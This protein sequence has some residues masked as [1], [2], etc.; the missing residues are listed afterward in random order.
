MKDIFISHAW[1]KDELNRDNH[2]RCKLLSEQLIDNGYSVWFDSNDLYGNIDSSIMKGINN[3][4]VVLV[5]LTNKYCDKINKCAVN[6]LTNDNCYKEWN[7]SLFKQKIIIPVLMEPNMINDFL[8]GDGIIQMYLNSLMFVDFTQNL[9]DDFNMLCKYL[10][11][12]NVM[13]NDE[14]KFYSGNSSSFSNFVQAITGIS[15]KSISPRTINRL[16]K[17]FENSKQIIKPKDKK[18]KLFNKSISKSL[19]KS[20]STIIKI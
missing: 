7:Y 16:H 10:K 4:K 20:A 1:G 12:N 19:Y 2:N 5:C 3:C 17:N 9:K 13:K 18:Y 6:Q 11:R 15:I 8:N 14:K